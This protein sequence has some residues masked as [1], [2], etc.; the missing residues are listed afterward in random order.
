M[1][2]LKNCW[3]TDMCVWSSSTIG[4]QGKQWEKNTEIPLNIFET[5]CSCSFY[6]RIP[7]R[8]GMCKSPLEVT[9]FHLLASQ[10]FP[11][12]VV[13]VLLY[14]GTVAKAIFKSKPIPSYSRLLNLYK[15]KKVYATTDIQ[16]LEVC[17]FLSD[18]FMP[19]CTS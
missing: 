16:H 1:C 15:F 10:V 13:K 6:C 9:S 8:I 11:E 3:F 5:A 14:P 2:S 17:I 19:Y 12:A 4:I 7:C 18:S